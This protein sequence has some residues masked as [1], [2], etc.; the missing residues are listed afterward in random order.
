MRFAHLFSVCNETSSEKS[1]HRRVPDI[2]AESKAALG[3]A[4]APPIKLVTIGTGENKLE[5]GNETVLFRHEQ[6]FYHPTGLAILVEDTEVNLENK[7][8]TISNSI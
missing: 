2:S 1:K 5:V 8:Q 4:S 7:I 3:A 6:T